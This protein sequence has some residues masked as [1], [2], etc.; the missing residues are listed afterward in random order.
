MKNQ[1]IIN[2]VSKSFGG[3]VVKYFDHISYAS[4]T[5]D[6]VAS[7]IIPEKGKYLITVSSFLR[8]NANTYLNVELSKGDICP[9]TCN[10]IL[11]KI[12]EFQ[13]TLKLIHCLTILEQ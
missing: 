6:T 9:G 8:G 11:I 1:E 7:L 10:S 4:A 5:K 12:M 3:K 13:Q 2:D